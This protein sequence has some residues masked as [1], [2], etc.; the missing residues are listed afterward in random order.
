M[1]CGNGGPGDAGGKRRQRLRVA[2]DT[3]TQLDE[4]GDQRVLRQV[5]GA[6]RAARACEAQRAHARAEPLGQRRFRVRIA[7]AYP[8]DERRIVN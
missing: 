2:Q 1:A 6:V 8:G 7:R 5:G 3:P 4:Q